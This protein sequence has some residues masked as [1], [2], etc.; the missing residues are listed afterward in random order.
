MVTIDRI[1]I[2]NLASY[3]LPLKARFSFTCVDVLP[4]GT[5]VH[6]VSTVPVGSH[7]EFHLPGPGVRDSCGPPCGC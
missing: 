7:R 5:G 2:L 1:K 4:A 3:S 6:H